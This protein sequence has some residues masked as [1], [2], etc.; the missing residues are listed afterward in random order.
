MSPQADTGAAVATLVEQMRDQSAV[1]RQILDLGERQQAALEGHDLDG[2]HVLLADKARLMT[3]LVQLEELA[4]PNR[5]V[6]DAHREAVPEDLRTAMR[7]AVADVRGLL[8]R[9]VEL[10]QACEAALTAVKDKVQRELQHL[11]R[12]GQALESYKPPEAP[13]ESRFLDLGM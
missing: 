2:F 4:A 1:Y 13:P 10:E 5:A 11:G 7:D 3:Q 9:L 12:G 8:E 6:W